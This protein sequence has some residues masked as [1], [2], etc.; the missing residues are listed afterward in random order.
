MYVDI[1]CVSDHTWL[2][3]S[4]DTIDSESVTQLK[5]D[6]FDDPEED[7]ISHFGKC[8]AFIEKAFSSKPTKPLFELF[9]AVHWNWHDN[10]YGPFLRVISRILNRRFFCNVKIQPWWSYLLVYLPGGGKVLV[11][12]HAGL[13]RSA[14]VVT[15]FIMKTKG[16][17]LEQA[18]DFVREKR[19]SIRPNEA[20]LIFSLLKLHVCYNT[21][22]HYTAPTWSSG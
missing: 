20:L 1:T 3:D 11:H 10:F 5:I 7:L 13:S 6:V 12:C 21:P 14:T 2:F 17:A 15:A 19:P 4:P 22:L 9:K 16:W 18:L 8:I